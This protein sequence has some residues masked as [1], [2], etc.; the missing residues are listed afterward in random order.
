MVEVIGFGCA[1]DRVNVVVGSS[2]RKRLGVND[3]TV[4]RPKNCVTVQYGTRMANRFS[5]E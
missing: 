4:S 2:H 1:A 3:L 5:G